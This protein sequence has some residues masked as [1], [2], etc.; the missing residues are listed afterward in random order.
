MSSDTFRIQILS[1]DG[2]TVELRATTGTAAGL[3]D[4]ATTRSFA[5]MAIEDGMAGDKT[6]PL[7]V[8]MAATVEQGNP[9]VW[10]TDW[11]RA[12][13]DKFIASTELR[14]RSNII[15]NDEAWWAE[16][17]AETAP[18]HQFVIRVKL[19][20][21]RWADGIEVGSSYGTTAFDAFWPDPDSPSDQAIATITATASRWPAS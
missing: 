19:A 10:E 9:P 7:Q 5:L 11:H 6:K 3:S 1:V 15:T 18:R 13:I 8:A 12:H 17:E 14:E 20:D 21:P 2:D 4:I 16:Y